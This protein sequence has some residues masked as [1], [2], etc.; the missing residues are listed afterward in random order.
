[1]LTTMDATNRPHLTATAHGTG[2]TPSTVT[3]TIGDATPDHG[4]DEPVAAAQPRPVH[5]PFDDAAEQ[6]ARHIDRD[7][8]TYGWSY[9]GGVSW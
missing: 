2:S 4:A 9:N 5:G 3:V 1:M 8:R 7:I 6:V